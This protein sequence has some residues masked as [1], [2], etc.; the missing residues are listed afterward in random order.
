[1]PAASAASTPTA[2]RWRSMAFLILRLLLAL[3]F[4]GAAIFKL[5]GHPAAIE[6]F[7]QVGLGQW[8]RYFTAGTELVSSLLL[9]LPRTVFFGAML[10]L[11]ICAGAFVAQW[12]ILHGD[13]IH[14][15]VLGLVFAVI[16][17]TQRHQLSSIVGR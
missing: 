4:T 15:V 2:S 16:A 14:S 7:D 6:E 5:S 12:Q 10:M 11:G 1:M 9:L 3:A 13:V 8:F 17:W